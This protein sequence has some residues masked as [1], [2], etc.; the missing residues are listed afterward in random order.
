[1]AEH[2]EKKKLVDPEALVKALDWLYE[3]AIGNVDNVS[4]C[5]QLA[6]DYLQKYN[7]DP[8]LAAKKMVI[9][10]VAKC[11][12]SG[13]LT[14][15]GGLITLPVAIP[16]N[17]TSVWYVQLQMIATIAVM[18]G[19]NPTHDEVKTLCYT[20]LTGTGVADALK[21]GGVQFAV[22]GGKVAIE[23]IPTEVLKAV[24]KRLGMRF[25]TK[26]GE[27]GI[28]NLGKMI[29]VLGGVVGGGFDYAS[30][31]IIAHKAIK[32]FIKNE[33]D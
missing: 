9:A 32:T 23:K 12:T 14:S 21:Q 33:I 17:I 7:H 13:F 24:N 8:E 6:D 16:V 29:P 27:K 19:Y 30:T 20:C 4:G 10:Q 15:L 25:V 26:F 31:S 28:V 5:W 1:M 2:E 22:R 11:T 18:G 3:K